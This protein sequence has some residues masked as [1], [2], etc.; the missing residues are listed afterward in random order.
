M[1]VTAAVLYPAS[2]KFNLDYYKEKHMPLAALKWGKYGLKSYVVSQSPDSNGE[3]GIVTTM[4]FESM[5]GFQKAVTEG[6]AE[7]MADVEKFSD[8]KP[9]M[10]VGSVVLEG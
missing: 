8:K 3:Y 6:G 9:V 2:A 1:T 7:V 4:V 5:E 10:Y